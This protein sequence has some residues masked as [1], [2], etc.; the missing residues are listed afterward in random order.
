MIKKNKNLE[1]L[2]NIIKDILKD[3]ISTKKLPR[4]KPFS[5]N[6][7]LSTKNEDELNDNN[8]FDSLVMDDDFVY[9]TFYT[10]YNL[11]NLRFEVDEKDNLI[12]IR[13][14]D[15]VYYKEFWFNVPI[16]KDSLEVS[17]KNN[18]FEIKLKRKK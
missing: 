10:S 7:N 14:H 5:L 18:I 8:D 9:L 16:I 4:T 2:D 17:F 11:N 1:A 15:F 12:M 3:V 6:I 13:S